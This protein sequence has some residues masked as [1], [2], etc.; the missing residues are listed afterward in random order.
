MV[1]AIS[2]VRMKRLANGAYVWLIHLLHLA[3]DLLP[4]P[5]RTL[6]WRVFLGHC[7]RGV[8]IDHHVY[9]KYPWLV[10][11]GDDVGI[12]RGV[13]F[14]PGKTQRAEIHIGNRVRIAPNVRLHAAGHDPD[15]PDLA[16]IAAPIDVADD[17]WIGAAAV[18]LPGVH[19]G[20]GAVIAAGAVVSRNVDPLAI[21]AGVPA[22]FVRS[23]K[24][25]P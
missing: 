8:M 22:R 25:G 7:G 18:I 4:G 17:A 10:H 9:F 21:V 24:A 19:I 20:H 14:Y 15:H 13:E 11:I 3:L 2:R 6:A 5:V 16:D 1:E 12:N 23:R